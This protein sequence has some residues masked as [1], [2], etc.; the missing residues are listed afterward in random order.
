MR[1]RGLKREVAGA[2]NI[3][4]FELEG[5]GHATEDETTKKM[6]TRPLPH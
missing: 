4:V 5:R 2:S 3:L 6:R 1:K